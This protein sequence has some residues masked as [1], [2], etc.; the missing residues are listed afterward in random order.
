M[1]LNL[2]I[3]FLLFL[4]GLWS[5][6]RFSRFDYFLPF[7]VILQ[8]FRKNAIAFLHPYCEM[9]GGGEVVLWKAVDAICELIKE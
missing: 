9:G 7:F 4:L 5:W 3:G 6:I 2:F 1:L 8:I